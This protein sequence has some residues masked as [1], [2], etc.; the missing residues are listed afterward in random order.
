[1]TSSEP[2]IDQTAR[3]GK[4]VELAPGVK[5]GPWCVLEGRIK[6]GPGTRLVSNVQLRGPMTIGENVILYPFACVG[7]P[8]QDFKVKDDA[9]SAGVLIGNNC[10]FREGVTIHAATSLTVPTRIG[11]NCYFM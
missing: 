6:L 11:N 7:F 2:V 9:P 3:V 8:A 1:M 4:E 10:T 5:I